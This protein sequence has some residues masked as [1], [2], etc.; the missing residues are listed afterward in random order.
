M[1]KNQSVSF[2]NLTL[3]LIG[4]VLAIGI[5]GCASS[6]KKGFETSFGWRDGELVTHAVG[7]VFNEQIRHSVNGS[8]APLLSTASRDVFGMSAE[9]ALDFPGQTNYW[10]NYGDNDT[11]G[12]VTAVRE[13]KAGKKTCW[14]FNAVVRTA[15][16]QG[17]I[18]GIAC[19]KGEND[20]WLTK[21]P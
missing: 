9:R 6:G 19:K 18:N 15:G 21:R 3:T 14:E 12:F 7:R 5:A 4:C 8:N 11:H 2:K 13:V 20:P 17:E 16:Y 10:N 1:L